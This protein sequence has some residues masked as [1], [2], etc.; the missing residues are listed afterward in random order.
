MAGGTGQNIQTF[1]GPAASSGQAMP[2]GMRTAAP[3]WAALGIQPPTNYNIPTNPNDMQEFGGYAGPAGGGYA[4]P[5]GEQQPQNFNLNTAVA[6]GLQG[7]MAGTAA[8]MG[9]NPNMVSNQQVRGTG[10]QAAQVGQVAPINAQQVQAGQLA[11]TNMG[12]YMNPYTE[13]VIR[14]NEA[15]ILRGAQ[16]GLN[17][18]GAQ[19][20]A[21]RAFGGSRQAITEAELGRN[22]AQQLAQSSA[23]LRQAGFTQAQQAAQQDIQSRMQAALANQQAG[24]AAGTTSAQLQQQANLAN[25]QALQQARQFGATQG[26]TAQQLNQQA[27]LQAA[28]AN[29]QAGLSGAQLRLG[30]AQQLG[31]LANLGFGMGQQTQQNLALQGALRQQQQ[32]A[33]IDAARAQFG[34]F[35]GSPQQALA[36]Q[37][38]AFG[39][40]QTGQQTTTSSYRPGLFDYLSLGVGGYAASKR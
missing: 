34:G 22:V 9:F 33:L 20:Q 12:Q 28:M 27:A 26:M 24:L 10:F 37:L 13:Q 36:T 15:D 3:N 39:G 38:G 8:G 29:Q 31:S 11:G 5:V 19:A 16:M 4:G 40:S 23:G 18:L 6:G 7:A 25:Q 2:P 30:A 1:S 35:A 14:A 32:Q 17:Q 21:A